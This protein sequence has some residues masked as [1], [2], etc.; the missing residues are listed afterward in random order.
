MEQRAALYEPDFVLLYPDGH[1]EVVDVKGME[2]R[3]F[4]LKIKALRERYP[5]VV[6]RTE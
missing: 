6:I 4:K 3:E 1:Y 2:T 5:R